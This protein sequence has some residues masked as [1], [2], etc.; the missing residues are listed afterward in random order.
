[1]P[2]GRKAFGPAYPSLSACRYPAPLP[3]PSLAAC[4]S[5]TVP[6]PLPSHSTFLTL[7][8]LRACQGPRSSSRTRDAGWCQIPHS[9]P[10]GTSPRILH[11]PSSG[12]DDDKS[13]SGCW[14]YVRPGAQCSTASILFNLTALQGDGGNQDCILISQMGKH[15]LR[16]IRKVSRLSRKVTGL[17]RGRAQ[18]QGHT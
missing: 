11:V 18:A 12:N 15:R 8:C 10:T 16:S 9:T 1:M 5:V 3:R 6:G 4:P 7:S 14:L 17:P 2:S 13:G